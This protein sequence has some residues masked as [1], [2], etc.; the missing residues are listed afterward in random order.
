MEIPMSF[1]KT[2]QKDIKTFKRSA[3]KMHQET[4]ELHAD[5]L[6]KIARQAGYH[7][8][9]HVTECAKQTG[10]D[11]LQ[12]D[13]INECQK[14]LNDEFEGRKTF[15]GL[16]NSTVHTTF[17]L[18]STGEGDVWLIEPSEKLALCLMWHY[19][20][21][22]VFIEE[23]SKNLDIGWDGKFDIKSVSMPTVSVVQPLGFY[24]ETSNQNIKT[25]LIASENYPIVEI[26][27]LLKQFHP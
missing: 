7:S 4:G 26:H 8:W 25:R 13:F 24:V 6:E 2:S 3:K 21:Q 18:F 19:E 27:E 10:L 17:Y 5:C 9:K 12:L 1:I 22:V 14:A 23:T 16:R 15:F 11:V 20:P